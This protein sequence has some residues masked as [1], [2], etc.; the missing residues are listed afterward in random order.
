MNSSAVLSLSLNKQSK[1]PLH[2]QLQ[3][4][5]EK[6]IEQNRIVTNDVLPSSRELCISLGVSRTTVLTAL[7]NMI[8][9]G[10]LVS[11]PKRGIYVSNMA[12]LLPDKKTQTLVHNDNTKKSHVDSFDSGADTK[13]FPNKAWA[14][15]MKAAWLSPNHKL[16]QGQYE[17]G[18]PDLQIQ[19]CEYLKQLRGLDCN[20]S[21][22]IVTA[23]NRDAL[24]IL[25]HALS[26][27]S[28]NTV[29]LEQMCFPQFS[30]VFKWLN[31]DQ[32]PLVLDDQGAQLPRTQA[33]GLALLTPCRHYPLGTP[34]SSL[35]RQEWIRFL[36]RQHDKNKP[37]YVIED[38]YDN[39]FVYHQKSA[40]PLMQQD[41]SNSV[42][43]VGSFSKIVFRGLRLG[44]IVCPVNLQTTIKSSQLSLGVA[45]ASAIQ[46]ALAHFMQSGHFVKHLRKMRRHYLHKRDF[47]L[48]TINT[49]TQ[50]STWYRWQKPSGGMHLCLYLKDK[51]Q[52]FEN[53]IAKHA[54][55]QGLKL[56]TL[57]SH[58]IADHGAG[59][60]HQGF[61]L[62]YTLPS[63]SRLVENLKRLEQSTKACISV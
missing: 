3:E 37:F 52:S 17:H 30:S 34:M 41:T 6:L 46:P 38:D 12:H 47:L 22:V 33:S 15:S 8:A 24:S 54:K 60:P 25:S 7:N 4:Q 29:H 31:M 39:E 49:Q 59:P 20:A 9:E 62:G 1:L 18:L 61:V 10:S 23:G 26:G 36:H 44:F 11:K 48:V 5:I 27:K 51:Y 55:E 42:I 13:V 40:L 28:N 43:F 19:I 2:R 53:I 35:R 21:Q 32:Q 50:L 57:S 45:G 58:Y 16:M 14:K 63:E 56:N